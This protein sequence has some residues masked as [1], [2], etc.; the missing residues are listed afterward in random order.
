MVGLGTFTIT[1]QESDKAALK[2][3]IVGDGYRHIDTAKFYKNEDIIGEALQ[4]ILDAGLVKREELFIT[5]KLWNDEADD[6]VAALKNSL[7]RL[8]LDYVD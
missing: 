8:K 1:N 4:E 2:K 5:T 6:P 7:S 3:A